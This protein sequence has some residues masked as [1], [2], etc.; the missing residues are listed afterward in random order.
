MPAGL[1]AISTSRVTVQFVQVVSDV[2]ADGL[3][4]Q[5]RHGVADLPENLGEGSGE[6]VVVVEA[7]QA[8]RFTGRDGP[9][10]IGARI[11][12]DG[13]LNFGAISNPSDEQLA[14]GA[15]AG[16][17]RQAV[18]ATR[19]RDEGLLIIYPITTIGTDVCTSGFA[20]SFPGDAEMRRHNYTLNPVAQAEEMRA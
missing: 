9:R 16:K 12:E 3:G 4:Q 11:R 7:L 15:S 13:V 10:P 19:T 5:G 14:R 2:P 8:R 17:T 20:L 6:Q 18:K 1:G